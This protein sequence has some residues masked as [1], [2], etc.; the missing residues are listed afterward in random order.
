ML[1]SSFSSSL[2]FS[3]FLLFLL[4]CSTTG[5]AEDDDDDDDA[6]DDDDDDDD[7]FEACFV[8]IALAPVGLVV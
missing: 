7:F 5:L 1:L 8:T 6:E 4:P 3:A 2:S